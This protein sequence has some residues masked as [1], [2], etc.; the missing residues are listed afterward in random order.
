MMVSPAEIHP[1]YDT[2]YYKNL[3]T[4]Q[5]DGILNIDDEDII[6]TPDYSVTSNNIL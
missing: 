6:Y 1:S 2:Y 5:H 4:N 3:K